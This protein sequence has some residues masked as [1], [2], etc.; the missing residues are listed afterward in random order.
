MSPPLAVRE[1]ALA[2]LALLA[3]VVSLAVSAQTKHSK[4]TL[5]KPEGSFTALAGSSGPQA[6][7]RRTACGITITAE[8][9]GVSNPTLPC[10]A[11]IFVTYRHSTVLVQVIDRGPYVPGRQ[12]DLTQAL[13]SR[14]GLSGVQV[15]RWSY[16]R[17]S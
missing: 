10:G 8:T 6:Y 7:G 15:I 16:A 3:A 14:L 13:A 1:I 11:R 9:E 17:L 2:G 4:T 12:F 5:P